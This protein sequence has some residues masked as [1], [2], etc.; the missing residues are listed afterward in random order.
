[1]ISRSV[2]PDIQGVRLIRRKYSLRWI[3]ELFPS[4]PPGALAPSRRSKPDLA[5][6][7]DAVIRDGEERL[8]RTD[9]APPMSI[10]CISVPTCKRCLELIVPLSVVATVISRVP[11]RY[12]EALDGG[13]RHDPGPHVHSADA[14]GIHPR[15]KRRPG[16]SVDA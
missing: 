16:G 6:M 11:Q 14:C 3:V 8:V 10:G 9:A 12:C 2:K 1:M 15:G 13:G 5:L 7:G 4:E